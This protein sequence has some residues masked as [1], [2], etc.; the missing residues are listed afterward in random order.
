[1]TAISWTPGQIVIP[2]RDGILPLRQP[3]F[4]EGNDE[5]AGL[6]GP[7]QNP[8]DIS[9]VM[10]VDGQPD[11][12]LPGDPVHEPAGIDPED[13]AARMLLGIVNFLEEG[14]VTTFAPDDRRSWTH[15]V[16][17]S[18]CEQKEAETRASLLDAHPEKA[19]TLL[20]LEGQ[21]EGA[22]ADETLPLPVHQRHM[23]H[24]RMS[25]SQR[26]TAAAAEVI[27]GAKSWRNALLHLRT[28]FPGAG[29]YSGVGVELDAA[30]SGLYRRIVDMRET[31]NDV[32]VR[33]S[34]KV[35]IKLEQSRSRA[36]Y[37][38]RLI[39]AAKARAEAEEAERVRKEAEEKA[40]KERI[41]AEEEAKLAAMR[42]AR[43]KKK[44]ETGSS[45]SDSEDDEDADEDQ[46]DM[47]NPYAAM[48]KPS[49]SEEIDGKLE[50]NADEDGE[51]EYD[52]V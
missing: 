51:N 3:S 31:L 41:K 10:G 43:A 38:E 45:D 6:H 30:E 36:A 29:N 18:V 27:G 20:P 1:M 52:D 23:H 34:T 39:L 40:E 42:A 49:G 46:I 21:A 15:E 13:T 50:E 25:I 37:R 44:L 17:M 26:A 11:T 47:V 48:L 5:S 8:L 16:L 7:Y 14:D 33:Q 22:E 2:D 32:V 35:E 9:S 24:L 12:L 28:M 19:G 4:K